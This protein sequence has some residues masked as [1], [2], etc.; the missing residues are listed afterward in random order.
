MLVLVGD[1]PV[2]AAASSDLPVLSLPTMTVVRWVGG[3][4]GMGRRGVDGVDE[5]VGSGGVEG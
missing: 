4:V 2:S 1:L 3:A 5:A